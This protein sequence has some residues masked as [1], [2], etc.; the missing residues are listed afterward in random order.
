MKKKYSRPEILFEHM[1]F[2][3]AIASACNC[4][5]VTDCKDV[6]PDDDR[7]DTPMETIDTIFGGT[8]TVFSDLAACDATRECY[9]VPLLQNEVLSVLS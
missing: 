1:E 9:H 7:N 2:N 8:Y 6:T 4:M 5:T 3:S